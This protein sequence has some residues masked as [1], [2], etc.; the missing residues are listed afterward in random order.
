MSASGVPPT[1][2]GLG[3]PPHHW[4][5]Q[6]FGSLTSPLLQLFE[7][8]VRIQLERHALR[9]RGAALAVVRLTHS[10]HLRV[11]SAG[12]G[13][14]LLLLDHLRVGGERL[15]SSELLEGRLEPERA[16]IS[17]MSMLF[18]RG[19]GHWRR[20]HAHAA[21]HLQKRRHPAAWR[22]TCRPLRASAR[23]AQNRLLCI[24]F[25][26]VEVRAGV[27]RH[28]RVRAVQQVAIA[29]AAVDPVA[30]RVEFVVAQDAVAL[31]TR[32]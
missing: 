4:A 31:H 11:P 21:V 15:D 32:V 28:F 18:V 14:R 17:T 29:L 5:S 9:P 7:A 24:S 13:E 23:H 22:A 26:V 19:A 3:T 30:L 1:G 25:R 12:L 10:H 2:I 16:S 8:L 27:P 6:S 20:R